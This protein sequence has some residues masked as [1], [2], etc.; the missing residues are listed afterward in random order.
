MRAFSLTQ[1]ARN[2]LRGIAKF[3]E[4]RWGRAQRMHYLKG[5]DETFRM[6]AAS[7]KLGSVCD[8]IEPGLRK[9]PFQSH[10]VF[11]LVYL[12]DTEIQVIRV[13]HKSMDVNQAAFPA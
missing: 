10:V 6:L 12:A 8:Y 13:L 5:L 11:Y 2:D 3:T 9:Y 7:P 4:E 1:A